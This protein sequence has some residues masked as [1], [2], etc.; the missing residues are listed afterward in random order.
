MQ[1]KQVQGELWSSAPAD[2]A[3]YLEPTFIPMYQS[4]LKQL[5]LDE[6]K[7]VLDAGCG[8]GLFLSMVSS[9]GASIQG[10]DAAPGLL[11]ISRER[12]PDTALLIEDL[13]ALPFMDETF[14]VV[15]GFNSFQY[16]GSFQNAL[17]EA[18][19]VTKKNGR[20]VIG[21]W[22][23]EEDCDAGSVLKA[24]AS[25]LPAPPPGTPGP[26]ALSE[27]GKVEAI[28][29]EAG[30]KVVK[31][32]SV[33]CP[34]TF[35]STEDLQ[36]GFLCTGPCVKAIKAMGETKVRNAIT[37]GAAPYQLAEGIYFMRNYFTFFITE[38]I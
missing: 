9:T 35:T 1:T 33:F 24:V 5:T 13:E 19:R 23:K 27:E 11:A 21:I 34:W 16:T 26:F 7:T 30:L 37:A 20:V 32:E 15:S 6:D 31:K 8:S 10:V 29:K 14:D 25:L 18:A 22:G 38:K 4:V 17:S 2:W 36:L 12:L 3:K 28:C